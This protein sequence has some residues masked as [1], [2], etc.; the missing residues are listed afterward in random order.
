MRV[1]KSV[2]KVSS[3][4]LC[5][6]LVLTFTIVFGVKMYGDS[7]A[8][9]EES[10]TF[11]AESGYYENAF[12][13]TISNSNGLTI[14]YTTDGSEPVVGEGSTKEYT[15]AI[16][17]T[18][19]KG[20]APVL[21][22]SANASKFV[23][24]DS[25]AAYV[26]NSANLDRAY[27]VRA[28]GVDASGNATPVS[29]RTYFVGNDIANKYNDCAVMSIVTDPDNLLDSDTGIY[30]TGSTYA[31]TGEIT[32]ANFS[33]K[34]KEWE[35][36][37]Y[38]DFFDGGESIADVSTGVGI[39]IH[40]GY[41][42][43]D[44]QKSLN[45]YFRNDYDYGTKTL[46]G[47]NLIPSAKK[48]YYDTSD[49][50]DNG[51]TLKYSNVM[52]RNGGNDSGISK[53]QDLFIQKVVEG[54][55]YATQSTRP[56]MVY[57]NGEY[58]GLYNLTEKYSDDY[59]E[60][61]FDV[62]KN[63]VIMYKNLEIDEGEDLDPDG[64]EYNEL[65]ALA[66]LDMSQDANYKKFTELVDVD[67]FIE[68][69][70]TQVY[71][72]NNDWWSGCGATNFNNI[73]FWK[74]ADP[75]KEDA[76]NPYA[77]GKWRYMLFDT[78]W[79]MAI[80]NTPEAGAEY[81][82]IQ[83]H[84]IGSDNDYN[85]SALFRE[86]F[87]NNDTFRK[88]FTNTLLD[89]RNWDFEYNRANGILTGLEN[90]YEPLLDI[91]DVRWDTVQSWSNINIRCDEL[92][93]F[94]NTRNNY[95]FT[96]LENNISKLNSS[97][98]VDVT[99]SAN[100]AGNSL[101]KINSIT[102]NISGGW[103]GTYYKSYPVTVT[104]K[105]KYG[106]DFTGW[107]VNGA[108]VTDAGALTTEVTLTSSNATIQ[109]VYER[110][111]DYV[112]AD[113]TLGSNQGYIVEYKIPFASQKAAGDK[114]GCEVQ[115]NDSTTG[116]RYGTVNLFSQSSAYMSGEEFG[117]LNLTDNNSSNV[118][119]SDSLNIIKT[120]GTI[121]IDGVI[122]S[123]WDS[124]NYVVLNNF[125]EYAEGDSAHCSVKAKFMWDSSNLYVLVNVKDDDLAT[126]AA[127]HESD[128]VEIFFDEDA[129]NPVDYTS[130]MFQHRTAFNGVVSDGKNYADV[131]YTVTS[132]AKI[133]DGDIKN[134][135]VVEYAVPFKTSKENGSLVDFELQIGDCIE[136][137]TS[138]I[139]K[140]NLFATSS[141]YSNR[142]VFGT[143]WLCD[144]YPAGSVYNTDETNTLYAIKADTSIDI[145][146]VVDEAWS[147]AIPFKVGLYSS[148]EVSGQTYDQ[149]VSAQAR[150]MWDDSKFY[151]MVIVVDHSLTRNEMGGESD[152]IELFFDET[153]N[154][155]DYVD[156]D[157]DASVTAFQY[158]V[159][160]DNT[161]EAGRNYDTAGYS[162]E[163]AS[164]VREIVVPTPTPAVK[165]TPKPDETG[166]TATFT[167]DSHASITTYL[168]QD[169]NDASVTLTN[170]TTAKSRDSETG[171]I[172]D[173][174]GQVNFTVVVDSGYVIDSIE[175]TPS[176]NY[177]NFKTEA[178]TGKANTYRITKMS[179]D[180]KVNVTT[181]EESAVLSEYKATFNTGGHASITTYTTQDYTNESGKL[182]NQTSAI[183]RNS[184]NG[185]VDI[186]GS[187]QVNFTVVPDANYVIESVVVSPISNYKNLKDSVDTGLDNTYRITKM[188]GNVVV[189]VNL[190][191]SD[192]VIPTKAP[193]AVPTK[194]P[195]ATP[196]TKPVT[197][198]APT[199]EP[200]KEP[201]KEPTEVPDKEPTG[202]PTKSPDKE[203]TNSPV[204][205]STSEPTSAPT[206]V[207]GVQPPVGNDSGLTAESDT[208]TYGNCI[209][210]KLTDSTVALVAPV[211][212]NIKTLKIPSYIK[213][214]GKKYN[215]TAI[216]DNAFKNCKKLTSV[217]IGKNVTTVGKSAF[218]NC[219]KL[220]KVTVKGK[221]VAIV[222]KKAFAKTNK[223]MSMKFPKSKYRVYA[224]K[225]FKK[226]G[227]SKST[228]YR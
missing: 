94:I 163:G 29:T 55:N 83:G 36:A 75:S 2:F 131:N 15:G 184:E 166:Y 178:D 172:V 153:H 152:N 143:A 170:Q 59:L 121:D 134:G 80:W 216:A 200:T 199:K 25:S 100:I 205:N 34:G 9:G 85:G 126:N 84:A 181:R 125:Q 16:S 175:V 220:K 110:N 103:T 132:A 195:T 87:E 141:P 193:T 227:Q 191:Y 27:I 13:L 124:A 137:V 135:Y 66:E 156:G 228:V 155:N 213:I 185:T 171:R 111:E 167:T 104:A 79:S 154:G 72:C 169:Y 89:I 92:R 56:C 148:K 186:T 78:E 107:S 71:I 68:Y 133:T 58:W 60:E 112:E 69:Y 136:G 35:R 28:I 97:G 102:P 128:S 129:A 215:V 65:M 76:D 188:T 5:I 50:T 4:V 158:R 46:K 105:E 211:S 226:K 225:V 190:V 8:Y 210:K 201:V 147:K 127:L 214:D 146:G 130:D 119:A 93:E 223:K 189:T 17:I 33:K 123:A 23:D 47:Y 74:V 96:M 38:M 177:K 61:E 73:Q 14:Y 52:V 176:T 115:I 53:I 57:L 179:G 202:E 209:Y 159:V 21:T 86:L 203:P 182:T 150:I 88:Q 1:K 212:K 173:S 43:R 208:V 39:R 30:V 224:T 20:Q 44:Q 63:N 90:Q 194:A 64:A 204:G 187:G 42:R 113:T 160:Y 151:V 108:T 62:D 77:D 138:R 120:Q 161:K 174:D 165:A 31:S 91:H 196:T 41:T 142:D 45:I 144:S 206:T 168:T 32:D 192:E 26:P 109:A 183:A 6:L 99:L 164:S 140:L 149:S 49:T 37:A 218:Y 197:T 19:L 3:L 48:T 10:L 145:D 207:P 40:G 24:K 222:G 162:V 81:D 180:V 117:T 70:A 101:V 217:V 54:R 51:D 22:T 114:V 116:K 12:N 118:V 95:I 7:T 82:S 11:S 139:G 98:R 122:D 18:N 219:K 198:V 67:S 106:Y 157:S 221:K